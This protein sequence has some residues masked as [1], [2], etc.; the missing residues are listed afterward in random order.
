MVEDSGR[1]RLNFTVTKRNS[2]SQGGHALDQVVT[3]SPELRAAAESVIKHHDHIDKALAQASDD[4]KLDLFTDLGY[5][6]LGFESRCQL[7]QVE[8]LLLEI[9]V[10]SYSFTAWAAF[11]DFRRCGEQALRD[12][13]P[14]ELLDQLTNAGKIVNGHT[15]KSLHVSPYIKLMNE[16]GR[17]L[18]ILSKARSDG[19]ELKSLTKVAATWISLNTVLSKVAHLLE[20]RRE[21]KKLTMIMENRHPGTPT[22]TARNP[23]VR[24]DRSYKSS[25]CILIGI[26]HFVSNAL[27]RMSSNITCINHQ[28]APYASISKTDMELV[29]RFDR[30]FN[31][32]GLLSYHF[33]SSALDKLQQALEDFVAAQMQFV[34]LLLLS[35]KCPNTNLA[36]AK[37]LPSTPA[38]DPAKDNANSKKSTAVA[39]SKVFLVEIT[40]INEV[41]LNGKTLSGRMAAVLCA[42]ACLSDNWENPMLAFNPDNLLS[43]LRQVP[44]KYTD[45]KLWGKYKSDLEK[46]KMVI[47]GRKPAITISGLTFKG[48]NER[49]TPETLRMD[50]KKCKSS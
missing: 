3:L 1:L 16:M 4:Y 28:P 24:F 25:D 31:H 20:N 30:L 49:I 21:E 40:S 2:E 39:K 8:Q 32:S 34:K 33:W 44:N 47:K 17:S 43:H 19:K 27:V 41:K 12:K 22:L 48:A 7:V 38:K 15:R 13:V 29:A 18:N 11:N 9:I 23:V 35:Y 36:P 26:E 6:S 5:I 14:N 37:E 45:R 50:L 46:H 42:L 10:G